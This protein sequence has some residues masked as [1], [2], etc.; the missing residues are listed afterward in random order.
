MAKRP[1]SGR[2]GTAKRKSGPKSSGGPRHKGG[3]RRPV[4]IPTREQVLEFIR[5]KKTEWKAEDVA[6]LQA[7]MREAFDQL[8]GE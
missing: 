2:T 3:T 4:P 7:G 8:L 5:E 1:Q 6:A